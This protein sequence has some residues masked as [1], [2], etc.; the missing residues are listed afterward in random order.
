M[1]DYAIILI[2]VGCPFTK[3]KLARLFAE[4]E[5]RGLRSAAQAISLSL[6]FAGV[7]GCKRRGR[8]TAAYLYVGHGV[9]E[10]VPSIV[11]SCFSDDGT[12]CNGK[13]TCQIQDS[14]SVP[15]EEREKR[16]LLSELWPMYRL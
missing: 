15:T 12:V 5:R 2:G 6:V 9:A 11:S 4:L 16:A 8:V 14:I 13:C 7:V 3:L 1:K 10:T